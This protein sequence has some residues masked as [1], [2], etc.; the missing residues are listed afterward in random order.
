MSQTYYAILTEIGEAKL[1]NATALGSTLQLTHMAVGDAGGQARPPERSQTALFGEK[2]RALLNSLSTDPDNLN[3]IIAEQVIPE[4]AGG[5][6]VREIGLFD[7]AGD[8]CAVAN[9][10][11]TYKPVLAS[12]SGRTQIIRMVLI[13][14]STEAVTLKI[15]P[16][17]VLATREHVAKEV[18][19]AISGHKAEADP[20]SQYTTAQEVADAIK[21]KADKA[22]TL[23][24]Y[25]ITDALP[26]TGKAADAD[27][28]DGYDSA[29][30]AKASDLEAHKAEADPHSQYTTAQE[31]AD[32]IKNKADKATT[33]DGY[34][35]TDALPKTGKAADADKLDGYDS[36]YFAKASDL[37]AAGSKPGRLVV[38]FKDT[39][40]PGTLVCN[41]AALNRATYAKL[42]AAIGTK[43]GVGDGSTTFNLPNIPDGHALLAANGSA[44]G[45]G[46]PGE[47]KSHSHTASSWTD[48]QGAHSHSI[49]GGLTDIDGGLVGGGRG[50]QAQTLS[51]EGAGAHAHNVGVTVNAA[52]VS[53]NLAAGLRLLVCI[54]YE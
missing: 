4:D 47:V 54:A 45:S 24:G 13:V 6:W 21:N 29:Y 8:L 34:G 30:F 20:H 40:E 46:T 18:S 17:V 43:Y 25:G 7:A 31:V 15:D 1:A 44:V 50:N 41:G 16:S 38:T 33:L 26:K 28:L 23:D 39:P 27:K 53:N 11:D 5:W 32:A 37:A 12:G 36:A 52:G 49:R 3:Q 51:T 14:T 9:C 22:T 10:P 48:S 2:R 35:I 42:F 19:R